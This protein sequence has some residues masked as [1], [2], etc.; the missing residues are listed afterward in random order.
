MAKLYTTTKGF[1]GIFHRLS[2]EIPVIDAP[3]V[4]AAR[5]GHTVWRLWPLWSRG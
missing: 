2:E 3:A 5:R 4:A 1:R